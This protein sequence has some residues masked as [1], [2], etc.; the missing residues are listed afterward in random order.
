VLIETSPFHEESG[1][2]AT[3]RNNSGFLATIA[4]ANGGG[5]FVTID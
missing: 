3:A 1:R 2:E 4:A 5:K